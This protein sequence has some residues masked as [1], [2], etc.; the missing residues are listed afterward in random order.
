MPGMKA[1]L[2]Y[3][4]SVEQGVQPWR[5]FCICGRYDAGARR[6]IPK[7]KERIPEEKESVIPERQIGVSGALCAVRNGG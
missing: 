2:E 1:S 7:E 3:P 5:A 4:S 6:R